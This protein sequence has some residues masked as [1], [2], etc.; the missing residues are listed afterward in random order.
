[1]K[2]I[3][4]APE[5]T[6]DQIDYPTIKEAGPDRRDFL[7]QVLGWTAGAGAVWLLDSTVADSTAHAGAA[8]KPIKGW[9]HVKVLVPPYPHVSG[10]GLAVCSIMVQTRN[11]AFA[12]FLIQPLEAKGIRKAI[13]PKLTGLQNRD[14]TDRKRLAKLRRRV[15]AALLAHYKKR[16]RRRAARPVVTLALASRWSCRGRRPLVRGRIRRPRH[17]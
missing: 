6:N 5:T 1:M 7:K 15:A 17:P 11:K 8:L 13:L 12:Q 16:T 3:K 14:V 10:S 4:P 9:Y 2:P